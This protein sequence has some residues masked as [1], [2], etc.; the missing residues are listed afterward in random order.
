MGRWTSLD[1][2]QC[3]TPGPFGAK[4]ALKGCSI[5]VR[6]GQNA[7]LMTLQ[8]LQPGRRR[9]ICGGE[10]VAVRMYPA[11]DMEESVL[12]EGLEILEAG[13]A[14]FCKHRHPEGGYPSVATG[15]YGA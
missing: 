7:P 11:F 3:N 15:D 4:T 5:Q 14:H 6:L 1:N 13:I 2:E 10:E 8:S 12:R 9:T